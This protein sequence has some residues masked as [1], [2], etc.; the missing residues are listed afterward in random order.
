MNVVL[1]LVIYIIKLLLLF[2]NT[3]GMTHPMNKV[4]CFIKEQKIN[5]GAKEEIKK[6]ESG[7][8]DTG[9]DERK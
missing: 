9:I 1:F 3:T 6:K 5:D 7:K 4:T 2:D 8:M